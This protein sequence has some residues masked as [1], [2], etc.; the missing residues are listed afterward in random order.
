[1][2]VDGRH[3]P[4]L[5]ANLRDELFL[6]NDFGVVA[7]YAQIIPQEV[8]DKARLGII[9][10][11]PSLLPKL[12]GASPIQTA[13]LEGHDK[14]GVN[15]FM[16]DEQVDHGP[17][18]ASRGLGIGE[19][20]YTDLEERL[21]DVGGELLL[22]TLPQFVIGKVN[23]EIQDESEATYTKKF[24][25][26]DGYVDSKELESAQNDGQNA[27]EILRK[28]RALNPEPGAYTM[29]DEKRTKLLDAEIIDNKLVLKEIQKEGG[30]PTRV[31]PHT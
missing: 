12:R 13:I 10:V 7:A 19:S 21:A 2:F 9:G 29:L 17:V 26:E 20:N 27:E 8:I 31:Y 15:L 11:H 16:L 22:E 3:R 23:K 5:A 14:T 24:S 4:D 1:V 18:I 25:T 28:I 6:D 30:V